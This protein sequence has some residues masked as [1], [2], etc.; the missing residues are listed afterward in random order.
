VSLIPFTASPGSDLRGGH[1]AGSR[2]R[3]AGTGLSLLLAASLLACSGQRPPTGGG[4]QPPVINTQE[5]ALRQCQQRRSTLLGQ[6]QD[7]RR[8]EIRLARLR[9]TPMPPTPGRPIWDEEKE[10]RFSQEDQELDRQ[11]YQ[12]D[13]ARW[14]ERDAARLA[15]WS[16]R[17]TPDIGASQQE[18]NRLSRQL[19]DQYP[20]LFTGPGSIEIRPQEL[21]RLSR[22]ETGGT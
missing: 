11:A 2:R 13:L 8:A 21:A 14:Q 7:L 4:K 12:R 20:Q 6:L 17:Q 5:P 3:I 10:S 18:L 15:A 9:S 1:G 16:Q 22:C 19:H